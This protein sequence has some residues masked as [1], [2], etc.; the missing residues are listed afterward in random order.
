MVCIFRPIAIV[1][2][3]VGILKDNSLQWHCI[4]I[5]GWERQ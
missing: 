3:C 1:M 4:I 2:D 5:E